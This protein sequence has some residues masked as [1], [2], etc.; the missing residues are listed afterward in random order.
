MS[1]V[2]KRLLSKISAA[3]SSAATAASSNKKS[4]S[5][6]STA[7]SSRRA[8]ASSSSSGWADVRT[9]DDLTNRAGPTNI[10]ISQTTA[11]LPKRN[12]EDGSLKFTDYPTFRPNQTPRE[13]IEAGSFGGCYFRPIVS[14]MVGG[15][16]GGGGDGKKS[17]SNRLQNQ[18][19]ELEC[20]K[21][22][23]NHLL[24]GKEYDESINKYGAKCGGSLQMWQSKGWIAD[25]DPYGW[26]QWYCRF[27]HGRR[28][29]DDARQV[30]RWEACTGPKGRWKRNLINKIAQAYTA[31]HRRSVEEV[32]VDATI[33]PVIR[34]TLLH[35]AYEVTKSDIQKKLDE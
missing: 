28:C 20:F 32:L 2:R 10:S 13:V 33:S 11:P 3:P 25:C 18:H 9:G 22:V 26:F 15:G 23:P 16:G 7:G 17:T 14:A 4:K 27:Y 5:S 6:T 21:D 29:T 8:S 30:K 35:W 34:Q 31:N 19:L 24:C 12:K 1:S